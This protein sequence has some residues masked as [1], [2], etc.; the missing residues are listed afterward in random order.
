MV[1]EDFRFSCFCNG[2]LLAYIIT[3]PASDA[4]FGVKHQFGF[5]PLRFRITTPETSQGAAFQKN[6]CANTRPIVNTE[7]LD[8]KYASVHII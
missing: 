7:T 2:M 3:V 1:K 6:I 4:L 5:G 8:I